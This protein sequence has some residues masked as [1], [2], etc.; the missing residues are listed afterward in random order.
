ML[1]ELRPLCVLDA[2]DRRRTYPADET[3][4]F[5]SNQPIVMVCGEAAYGYRFVR[6]GGMRQVVFLS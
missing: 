6:F 5:P 4:D 1:R 3:V 2:G